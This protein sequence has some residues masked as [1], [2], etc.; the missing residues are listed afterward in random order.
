M[1]FV[2]IPYN[3]ANDPLQYLAQGLSSGLN[4]V[5]QGWLGQQQRQSLNQDIRTLG[6]PM[7]PDLSNPML[8]GQ[9]AQ[10]LVS[11]LLPKPLSALER[12]QTL[13]TIAE[14]GQIGQ[15]APLTSLDEARQRQIEKQTGLLGNLTPLEQAQLE[16]T[17]AETGQIG[18]PEPM[19]ALQEAQR[20][21]VEAETAQ[22]GKMTPLQQAQIRQ[23]RANIKHL[24]TP[25]PMSPDELAN[26]KAD[27]E[28]K[29]NQAK[30]AASNATGAG[31]ALTQSNALRGDYER[32]SKDFTVVRD[33][34]NRMLAA[35]RDPSAAGDLAIIFSYMK[36]LDPTSVVR[37]SEQ[38][39]AQNAAGVPDWLRNMWNKALTGERIAF[40]RSDFLSK[41]GEL[42]RS[43]ALRQ[44]QRADVYK[45]IALEQNIPPNW[46]LTIPQTTDENNL[47]GITSTPVTT[48]D[49]YQK[50]MGK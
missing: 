37:E 46:V 7:M 30:E 5:G 12:A 32:G 20:K 22:I 41:A 19:N 18:L 14:T 49:L 21:Q 39:S 40:T 24:D 42:Y 2:H 50:A 11:Q 31:K 47:G 29:L 43:Q 3:P 16:K 48:D 15:P 27:T 1:A 45:T 28:L 33:F 10:A 17:R 35:N 8:Q 6:G 25:K 4:A 26:L 38:A 36:I 23:I 9:I 34:Y 13:K 44:Q